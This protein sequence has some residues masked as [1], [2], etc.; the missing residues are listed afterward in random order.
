MVSHFKQLC[1]KSQEQLPV[2]LPLG[3]NCDSP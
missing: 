3:P 2:A 1:N